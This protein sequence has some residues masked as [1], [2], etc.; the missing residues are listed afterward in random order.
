[1]ARLER[2]LRKVEDGLA[3]I[4]CLSHRFVRQDELTNR[5]VPAGTLWADGR[6]LDP[7]GLRIGIREEGGDAKLLIPGPEPHTGLLSVTAHAADDVPFGGGL[8]R[9]AGEARHRE[10]ERAPP[11]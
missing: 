7:V 8:R 1:G 5:R 10:V 6:L 9:A 3:R 11:E 4:R 2:R